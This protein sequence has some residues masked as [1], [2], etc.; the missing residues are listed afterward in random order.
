MEGCLV[1]YSNILT[2]TKGALEALPYARRAM[3]LRSKPSLKAIYAYCMVLEFLG[4]EEESEEIIDRA[5]KKVYLGCGVEGA[6]YI[7]D[8]G[9][10]YSINYIYYSSICLYK[11][12]Y[13]YGIY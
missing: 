5:L 3:E 4:R 11:D 13:L 2:Y 12:S 10:I 7:D 9:D 6:I 8:G 1:A